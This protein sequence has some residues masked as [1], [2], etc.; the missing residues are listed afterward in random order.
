MSILPDPA[1]ASAPLH[2]SIQRRSALLAF[3][4]PLSLPEQ[5]CCTAL[6]AILH[7]LGAS[8]TE[9]VVWRAEVALLHNRLQRRFQ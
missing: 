4:L 3:P 7:S 9:L 8:M 1:C 6:M 2:P 5:V